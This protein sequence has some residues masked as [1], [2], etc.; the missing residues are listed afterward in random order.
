MRGMFGQVIRRRIFAAVLLLAFATGSVFFWNDGEFDF[1]Q[2][3]VNI[4]VAIAGFAWLHFRWR[5]QE[6]RAL[7]PGK[8]KDIFE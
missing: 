2:F 1:P 5:A 6:Q 8:V 4:V 7:T 3:S